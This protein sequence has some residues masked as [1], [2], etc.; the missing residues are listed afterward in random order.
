MVVKR[1]MH[2]PPNRGVNYHFFENKGNYPILPIY[3][4][5][6]FQLD[7]AKVKEL[8][9]FLVSNI[10]PTSGKKYVRL[11]NIKEVIGD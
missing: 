7:K 9:A 10:R 1:I 2:N 6:V 3:T 8:K 11:E 4:L 5:Q